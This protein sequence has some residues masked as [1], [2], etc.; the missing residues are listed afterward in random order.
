M[1]HSC[2]SRRVLW[3][4]VRT[5]RTLSSAATRDDGKADARKSPG[6][7]ARRGQMPTP[8]AEADDEWRTVTGCMELPLV[9]KQRAQVLIRKGAGKERL[10]IAKMVAKHRP[11]RTADDR[12]LP[13]TR[14]MYSGERTPAGDA[15]AGLTLLVDRLP[16][17]YA[18]ALR[19]LIELRKRVPGFVP[20]TVLLHGAGIGAAAF[21]VRHAWPDDRPEVL[22]RTI[23]TEDVS[24]HACIHTTTCM[25]QT[26]ALRFRARDSSTAIFSHVIPH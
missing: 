21:A 4:A 18:S 5:A 17:F 20:R 23:A 16:A 1:A 13:F 8:S 22:F 15:G 11:E 19:P 2:V 10:G 7:A 25:Q 3:G 14:A 6:D 26:R 9:M 24:D 12:G